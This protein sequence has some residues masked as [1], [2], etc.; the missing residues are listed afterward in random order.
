MYDVMDQ[1]GS[2]L[3]AADVDHVRE[4]VGKLARECRYIVEWHPALSP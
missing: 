1:A 2:L 4:E 3:A